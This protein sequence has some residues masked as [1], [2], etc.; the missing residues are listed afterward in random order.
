MI[1]VIEEIKEE[2]SLLAKANLKKFNERL[3]PNALPIIGVKLPDLRRLA[4]RICKENYETFL[5]EYDASS[6]ELQMLYGFVISFAEM[7]L[8]HRIRYLKSFVPTIQD[9]AIC[10]SLVSA[11]KCTEENRDDILSYLQE[12]QSSHKEFEIRFVVV[13][14]MSYF[15]IDSYVDKAIN[16]VQ[17]LEF[18]TYYAKMGVSWFI[19]TL[20]IQYQQKALDLLDYL[21]D[22]EITSFTI[23]KIRDSYRVKKELKEK[24][25]EFRKK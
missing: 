12:Y 4:K 3:I 25:L 18:K 8:E 19:A 22:E 20:I 23:R 1:V 2:L 16:I 13:M 10:D 24:I 7:K 21:K 17:N 9:W 15:L 14:L 5:L 6:F 11:L